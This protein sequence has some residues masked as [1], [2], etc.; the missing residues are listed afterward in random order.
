MERFWKLE[1]VS[2]ESSLSLEKQLA[3]EIFAKNHTR[4]SD[5]RYEVHLPFKPSTKIEF[6]DSFGTAINRFYSLE[7]R[8]KFNNDLKSQYSAFINE[9][10][11]L[12]HMQE[13]PTNE[14]CESKNIYYLPHHAIFKEDSSTTKIRIVFDASAKSHSSISLNEALLVGPT[15]QRDI[16]SICLCYRRH[17]YVISGDI[18]KMYRQIW[19]TR[20]HTDFQRIV[21]RQNPE[22]PLKHYRLLTVTYGTS[23]APFLAVRTLKQLALDSTK[24]HPLAAATLLNDFYVDDVITGADTIKDLMTL[25]SE[26]V[27]LLKSA[28]FN[29][30]KWTTNCWPV[31]Y[32]YQRMSESCL[33]LTLKNSTP[34]RSQAFNGVLPRIVFPTGLTLVIQRLARNAVFYRTLHASSIR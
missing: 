31:Y 2:N 17:L 11:S 23:A 29:L 18:E 34:S 10:L 25:Q 4:R 3:E 5:G 33:E 15:I 21:W 27:D 1:E 26:L 28:G 30:R 20:K 13:I 14:V 8:F 22:D 24:T 6:G 32:Q 9:Y 16:F 19:I 12:G 7:W